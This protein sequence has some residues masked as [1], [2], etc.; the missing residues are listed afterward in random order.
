MADAAFLA[1]RTA[2]VTGAV[3]GLGAAMVR[4]LAAAGANV[5]ICD[6]APSDACAS[7]RAELRARHGIDIDYHRADLA[8][9]AEVEGLVVA[10]LKRFGSANI[11]INN[12]VVRHFAPIE[13]FPL[14]H[15]NRAL[16]VNLTAAF[17]AT[18]LLLPVMRAAGY[19][20]IFN[21]SSVYGARGT[22]NRV[23]YVTTKTA[24]HGLTR[25]TA[26]E[27]AGSPISCH[28]LTPGTVQTPGVQT[29]ID[30]L[31]EIE[32]LSREAAE[33]RFLAGKQPNGQFID[34]DSVTRVMLLLCGPTGP[35]MNGAI[36]PIEGG[37]L[38]RS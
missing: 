38:A 19:G 37:W 17:V 18:Q 15:W 25:A 2:L 24:L 9:P 23:D 5:M 11:L 4:G 35:D 16:A 3:G 31:M 29:R 1:G 20:R 26:M 8:E 27:V 7:M 30:A 34:P 14:E 32:G 33:E 22:V 12:A 28:A 10:T 21:L 36:L 6:L 13:T